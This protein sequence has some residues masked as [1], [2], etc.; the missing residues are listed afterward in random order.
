LCYTFFA[1]GLI[2]TLI[3]VVILSDVPPEQLDQA[4]KPL[5]VNL[6]EKE[7]IDELK[8][9]NSIYLE[10]LYDLYAP[11]LFGIISKLIKYDDLAEDILQETFVKTWKSINK[12]D[13]QKGKLFTWMARIAHNAAIDF[14]REQ[15]G[16]RKLKTLG[17]DMVFFQVEKNYPVNYNTDTIGVRELINVLP[18]L[19]KQILDLIYFQGY[20]QVEVSDRLQIPLGSVKSKLRYAILLLRDHFN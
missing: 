7:L 13:P 19:Q 18:Q 16:V 3:M 9:G 10:K 8:A 14:L 2:Y 15:A 11:A 5:R 1:T 4:V 20:T 17:I 6:K 12:F